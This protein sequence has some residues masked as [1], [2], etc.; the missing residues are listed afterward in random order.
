MSTHNYTLEQ[1][2]KLLHVGEKALAIIAFE[3][4]AHGPARETMRLEL[5]RQGHASFF[6]RMP[7]GYTMSLEWLIKQYSTKEN[8]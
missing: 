5:Q 2:N 6:K 8:K 4:V 3:Q 7:E 1:R